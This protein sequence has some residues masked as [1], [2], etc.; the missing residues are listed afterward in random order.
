MTTRAT[1]IKNH[2]PVLKRNI[3]SLMTTIVNTSTETQS[4]VMLATM[5][6]LNVSVY[7]TPKTKITSPTMITPLVSL[8]VRVS[9]NTSRIM[10]IVKPPTVM[11]SIVNTTMIRL[12]T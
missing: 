2:S 10:S 4:I 1:P 5:M 3:I 9:V 12:P 11:T 7:T 8:S 6:R